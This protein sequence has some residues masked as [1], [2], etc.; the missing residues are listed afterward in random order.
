MDSVMNMKV[1][2]KMHPEDPKS[3]LSSLEEKID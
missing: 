3:Q 2:M 1:E